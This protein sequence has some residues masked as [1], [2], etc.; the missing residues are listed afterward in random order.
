MTMTQKVFFLKCWYQPQVTR[1]RPVPFSKVLLRRCSEET[2]AANVGSTQ[3]NGLI[4]P[5]GHL[6]E[7]V[8]KYGLTTVTVCYGYVL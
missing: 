2:A 3:V 7:A 8:A 1:A 5:A 6:G 4:S